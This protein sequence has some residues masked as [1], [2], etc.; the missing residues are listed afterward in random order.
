MKLI[1]NFLRALFITR[2]LFHFRNTEKVA[3]PSLKCLGVDFR[4]LPKYRRIFVR[5]SPELS[6]RLYRLG[7]QRIHR[8]NDSFYW[9]D[10]NI[11]LELI[12]SENWEAFSKAVDIC[13]TLGSKDIEEVYAIISGVRNH[14]QFKTAAGLDDEPLWLWIETDGHLRQFQIYDPV[15][16]PY[17]TDEGLS[18][19]V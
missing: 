1:P 6:E 16:E 10:H 2:V 15:T 19:N 14:S 11:A 3:L 18:L 4:S 8:R 5:N 17:L 12:P 7:F 9:E 13:L